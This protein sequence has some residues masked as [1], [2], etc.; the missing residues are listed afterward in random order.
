MDFN[1]HSKICPLD[2][3]KCDY[4]HHEINSI[5]FISYHKQL[6]Y[7]MSCM[8]SKM[9]GKNL[10]IC[11]G[12]G[13]YHRKLDPCSGCLTIKYCNP[14]CQKRHWKYHKDECQKINELY[15]SPYLSTFWPSIADIYKSKR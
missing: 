5:V 6:C 12:C 10:K 11:D 15:K 1:I 2:N 7:Q 13:K 9:K 8:V 3:I 14:K 4:C